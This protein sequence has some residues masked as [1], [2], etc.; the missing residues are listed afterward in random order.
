MIFGQ[1]RTI[2]GTD[3]GC[4]SL[5]IGQED[6]IQKMNH[7]DCFFGTQKEL[8]VRIKRSRFIPSFPNTACWMDML[9]FVL[10]KMSGASFATPGEHNG[11]LLRTIYCGM[12][13]VWWLGQH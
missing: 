3:Q 7:L 13:P 2:D 1:A 11:Q 6:E 8:D 10:G 9:L 12:C 4:R 5:A